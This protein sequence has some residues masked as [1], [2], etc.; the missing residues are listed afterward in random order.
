MQGRNVILVAVAVVLGLLAV[1]IANAWFT[2]VEKQQAKV[3]QQ[4]QMARIVV[5]TQDIPFGQPLTVQNLSLANWPRD[6]VPQGAFTSIDDARKDGRVAL[7]PIVV[8]EPVLLSKVSGRATLSAN[9]P[10]GMVAYSIPIGD[11]SG[12]A[13]FVR[14]GDMVDVLLTRQIPGDG[15][16]G[17]D[18]MTDVVLSAVPVLAIDTVADDTK[19]E[20]AVGKTATLQVDRLGAQKLALSTQLGTL[21]LALRNATDQGVAQASTVIPPQL[22]TRNLYIRSRGTGA[23][24]AA[25]L[26]ASIPAAMP[27]SMFAAAA[28]FKPKPSGPT[29][30]VVRGSTSSEYE[31][32]RGH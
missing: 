3:A 11:V 2:G 21:T 15:A 25:S 24:P 9:V 14:P 1:V 8:G 18:K 16:S 26:A 19:T 5:A 29:M 32:Q 4:Q 6:S 28:A 27:G 10:V 13:G 17:S 20:P 23:A 31:V 7:R 12:V 30:T 22:T